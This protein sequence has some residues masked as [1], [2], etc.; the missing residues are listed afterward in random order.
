L[1]KTAPF[2]SVMTKKL[3]KLEKDFLKRTFVLIR[4]NGLS[5]FGPEWESVLHQIVMH[6]LH[7]SGDF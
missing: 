4:L 7:M 2:A 1:A 3:T 5:V 6:W